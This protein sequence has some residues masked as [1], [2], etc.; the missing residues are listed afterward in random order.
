MVVQLPSQDR[1][2]EAVQALG[3]GPRDVPVDEHV[4]GRLSILGLAID[5]T[6]WMPEL[7]VRVVLRIPPN[8]NGVSIDDKQS[9]RMWV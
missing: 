4:A 6:V 1:S 8:V 9:K 3:V 7:A 5:S 2:V